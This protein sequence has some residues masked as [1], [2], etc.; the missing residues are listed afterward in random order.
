M[1]RMLRSQFGIKNG[2]LQGGTTST[3]LE[4]WWWGG[5]RQLDKP[6][7]LG[8]EQS[9]LNLL[10]MVSA[11]VAPT[12]L[13]SRASGMSMAMEQTA[14]REGTWLTRCAVVVTEEDPWPLRL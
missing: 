7:I 13:V 4:A 10:E 9:A 3:L 11:T 6:L 8:F 2:P 5:R 1:R 14:N 12:H